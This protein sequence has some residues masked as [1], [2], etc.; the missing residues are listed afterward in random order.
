MNNSV[1]DYD[2]ELRE[3]AARLS[4]AEA[5]AIGEG[6]GAFEQPL[7]RLESL[8]LLYRYLVE[9]GIIAQSPKGI[10]ILYAKIANC[11]IGI[12][13]LLQAGYPGPAAMVLRSLFETAVHLQVILKE[14]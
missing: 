4:D 10:R 12:L 6:L 1:R 7:N 13:R 11:L 3:I 5:K 9:R 8:Y 14:D 2:R